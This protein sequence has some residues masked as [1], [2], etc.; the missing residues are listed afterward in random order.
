M[1]GPNIE[2][3]KLICAGLH[4]KNFS[5]LLRTLVSSKDKPPPPNST[6]HSGVHQPFETIAS[7]HNLESALGNLISEEAHTCS[8]T[9]IGVLIDGGQ[10]FSIQASTSIAKLSN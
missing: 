1:T 3:P 4:P 5:R 9:G 8:E 7:N 6:G 2:I 10:L